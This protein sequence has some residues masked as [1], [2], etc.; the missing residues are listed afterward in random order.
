MSLL[1]AKQFIKIEE[2]EEVVVPTLS[3]NLVP[4]RPLVPAVTSSNINGHANNSPPVQRPKTVAPIHNTPSIPT[5]T[6]GKTNAPTT[7]NPHNVILSAH[8]QD[9]EIAGSVNIR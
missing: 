1:I 2:S 4:R 7:V 5:T 3:D 6:A 8:P 9:N